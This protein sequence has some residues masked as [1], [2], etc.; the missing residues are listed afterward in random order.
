M[1]GFSAFFQNH[2]PRTSSGYNYLFKEVFQSFS[3]HYFFLTGIWKESRRLN[4]LP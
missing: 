3:L 4:H 2:E 1:K